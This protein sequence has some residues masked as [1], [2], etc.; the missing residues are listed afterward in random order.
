VNILKIKTRFFKFEI[1]I[2][3]MNKKRNKNFHMR[4]FVKRNKIIRKIGLDTDN[5]FSWIQNE[6]ETWDYKP[7]IAKREN[8][9]H[10]NYV[11]FSELISLLSESNPNLKVNKKEIFDFLKRNK[12]KPIKKKDVDEDKVNE[13]L[14]LLKYEKKKRKWKAGENDLKIIAIYF[15]AGIPCISTNNLQDFK[16]PCNYLDIDLDVPVIIEP[17]SGQDVNRMLKNL[18]K[19][20][21][22]RK[23]KKRF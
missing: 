13:T 18:S 12:I 1:F 8:F 21:P 15:S 20:N 17:G 9:L 4:K 22:F 11:V 3:K 19:N 7:K 5:Y 6:K 16:D 2:I 14:N 10:L 23:K